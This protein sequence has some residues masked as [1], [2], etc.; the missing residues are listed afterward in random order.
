MHNLEEGDSRVLELL[1]QGRQSAARL[2]EAKRNPHQRRPRGNRSEA[3][4]LPEIVLDGEF[5]RL[6]GG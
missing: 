1:R 4:P 2:K 3:E 5:E 6:L